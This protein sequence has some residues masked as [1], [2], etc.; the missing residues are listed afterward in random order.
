METFLVQ[1]AWHGWPVLLLPTP[2]LFSLFTLKP[3]TNTHD[4]VVHA[5]SALHNHQPEWIAESYGIPTNVQVHVR[6]RC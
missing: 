4:G 2:L 1:F 5:R 3:L 6:T